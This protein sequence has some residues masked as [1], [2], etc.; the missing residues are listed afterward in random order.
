MLAVSINATSEESFANAGKS[1]NLSLQDALT[2]PQI[3][4]EIIGSAPYTQLFQPIY[5][6]GESVNGIV[7]GVT[8]SFANIVQVKLQ[9]GRFVSLLINTNFIV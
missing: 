1:D 5:F 9:S 3:D 2:L 7:L 6:E 8:D 4:N